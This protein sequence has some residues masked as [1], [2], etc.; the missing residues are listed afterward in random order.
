MK[1]QLGFG[2]GVQAE[3]IR[4]L[5]LPK[6]RRCGPQNLRLAEYSPISW[7]INRIKNQL[8]THT[9]HHNKQTE[10]LCSSLEMRQAWLSASHKLKLN[11]AI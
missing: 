3:K 1:R 9:A 4:P 5:A 2:W 6:L 8:Q 10:K 7:N 11:H